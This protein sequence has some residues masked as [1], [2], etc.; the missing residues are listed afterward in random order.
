M[1]ALPI[2]LVSAT[3]LGF[4]IFSKKRTGQLTVAEKREYL[5]DLKPENESMYLAM[6]TIEINELYNSTISA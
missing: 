2:I 1:K 3:I 4:M 5:I 6:T